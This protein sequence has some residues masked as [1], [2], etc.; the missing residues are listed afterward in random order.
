MHIHLHLYP[1][2]N[3]A[4][5]CSEKAVPGKKK[6]HISSLIYVHLR[7]TWYSHVMSFTC[8]TVSKVIILH[9]FYSAGIC[10]LCNPKIMVEK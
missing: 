1:V 3:I 8:H 10:Q 4:S 6:C 9:V 2:P 5:G 7:D